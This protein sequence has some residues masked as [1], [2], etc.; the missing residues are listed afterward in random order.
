MSNDKGGKRDVNGTTGEFQLTK[1]LGDMDTSHGGRT[2]HKI[3]LEGISVTTP[4]M[5]VPLNQDIS[6]LAL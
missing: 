6:I 5:Y 1:C 4:C 3:R 2:N